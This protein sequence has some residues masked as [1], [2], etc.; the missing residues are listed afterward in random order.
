MY[1][2]VHSSRFNYSIETKSIKIISY[3]CN[4]TSKP[5][6]GPCVP[7]ATGLAPPPS[8]SP[9]IVISLSA[10]RALTP[11]SPA[12]M[13]AIFYGTRPDGSAHLKRNHLRVLKERPSLNSDL[14]R[15]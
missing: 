10:P 9:T 12:T 11:R 3:Y 2:T 7:Q 14:K 5:F 13:T 8:S 6:V 1:V 4:L 15:H